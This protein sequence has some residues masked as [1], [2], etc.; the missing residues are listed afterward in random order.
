MLGYHV[1]PGFSEQATQLLMDIVTLV[2]AAFA[3]YGRLVATVP[4]WFAKMK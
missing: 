2:G 4:G 1:A 3:L